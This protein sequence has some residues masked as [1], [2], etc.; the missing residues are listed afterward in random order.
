VDDCG[1]LCWRSVLGDYVRGVY[2]NGAAMNE[3]TIDDLSHENSLIRAR[4]E[5]LEAEK[6]ELLTVLRVM[7][8]HPGGQYSTLR[9]FDEAYESAEV[10]V[11]RHTGSAT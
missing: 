11:N 4:N 10:I 5:R 1:M 7:L 3:I 9:G 6:V 2:F 8:Q